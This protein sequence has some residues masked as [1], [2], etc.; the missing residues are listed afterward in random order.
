MLS[1]VYEQDAVTAL[2]F[3]QLS[4]P[5]LMVTTVSE[6]GTTD[7]VIITSAE[8][9]VRQQSGLEWRGLIDIPHAGGS[10]HI[11]EVT[12]EAESELPGPIGAHSQALYVLNGGAD[13]GD[14]R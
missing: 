3:L 13:A 10:H 8:V 12:G 2:P 6:N 4:T 5:D 1:E 7:P 14:R 11:S 9:E